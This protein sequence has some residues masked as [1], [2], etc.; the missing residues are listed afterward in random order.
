MTQPFA[1]YPL[2]KEKHAKACDTITALL[3][4]MKYEDAQRI[5]RAAVEEIEGAAI[6]S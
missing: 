5:L 2:L 3:K 1:I 6:L 4:G